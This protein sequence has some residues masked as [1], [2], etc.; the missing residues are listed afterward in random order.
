MMIGLSITVAIPENNFT[1][2]ILA[3]LA[4]IVSAG[5]VVYWPVLAKHGYL[6][7]KYTKSEIA[8][9]KEILRREK[10]QKANLQASG[11]P[12]GAT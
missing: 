7:E 11:K 3:L 9:A 1:F 2:F 5:F 6:K 4:S 8:E 12:P 10:C